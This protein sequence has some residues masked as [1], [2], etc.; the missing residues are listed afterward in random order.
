[1]QKI[2]PIVVVNSTPQIQV[3]VCGQSSMSPIFNYV[4]FIFPPILTK[5]CQQY[6]WILGGN[7][8]NE[9]VQLKKNL[10]F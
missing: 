7:K 5:S 1:M 8:P 4:A 10:G 3:L 6:Q 9:F 2:Y